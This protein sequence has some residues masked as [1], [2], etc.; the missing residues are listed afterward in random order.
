CNFHKHNG[1]GILG[2]G[3]SENHVNTSYK[4]S[5][6]IPADKSFGSR[7]YTPYYPK[8]KQFPTSHNSY[9][10][11]HLANGTF[12]GTIVKP[13]ADIAKDTGIADSGCS[14]SMSGNGDKLDDFMDFDGG[15]VRFRGSNGMIT[16]KGTIKTKNLDFENVLYV[17][18]LEPFNLISISQVCDQS[19]RVLFTRNECLVLSKDFPPPDPKLSSLQTQEQEGKDAAQR[20]GLAF[21]AEKSSSVSPASTPTTFVG[22]TPP[23]SP[24]PSVGHSSKSTGKK[25]A[26][27]SKTPIPAGRSISADKSISADRSIFA[28]R[29]TN[30][31]DRHPSKLSWDTR[32]V[33]LASW[34][35]EF[36]RLVIQRLYWDTREVGLASWRIRWTTLLIFARSFLVD[37]NRVTWSDLG[38]EMTTSSANNSVF[39]GFFEKQKLS[40]P[41]FIDWYQQFRIVLSIEDKLN[42]LE[43]AIPP[44]P[45]APE[46]ASSD[47][48]RFSLLQAGRRQS[49]SSYVLKIKGYIDN[50]DHLGHPGIIGL[51]VSLIY[52]DLRKEYDGFVQNYNM[53]IMGK[54]VNELHA[55][56]KLH[57]QTL[58]K[59]NALTLHAIQAGKV[60]KVNKHKKPQHQMAARGQNQGK[61]KNKLAY[62]PKPKIPSPPKREDPAKDSICH[63]CGKIGH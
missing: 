49:V 38:P 26:S 5:F 25:L 42:Y 36:R 46:G 60:Q 2:K 31:A 43:Q 39:K 53:H 13:S 62:A 57:E 19:H 34:R 59:N 54:T 61:R 15:P 18:E 8:S 40:G 33:G 56:L 55:M 4:R 21:P 51:V 7:A 12:G 29:D 16:G 32:E 3:P 10:S 50:L 41:N 48:E 44:A 35:F 14:R 9:Y 45:V 23:V 1:K 6:P 20:L 27:S 30:S 22:N 58:P 17:P 24:R 47:Y 52:I 11:M 28:S 37:L 63:E